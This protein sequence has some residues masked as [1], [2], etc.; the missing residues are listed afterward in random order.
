V[1][2]ETF[3]EYL[4]WSDGAEVT[5]SGRVFQMLALATENDR[6]P[7]VVK[8]KAETARRCVEADLSLKRLGMSAT[9]VS[10]D[11]K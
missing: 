10:C 8:R 3:T 5:S 2:F 4:E 9:R 11:D 7:T 1:S 6:L